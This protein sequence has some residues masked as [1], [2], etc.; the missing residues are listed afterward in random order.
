MDIEAKVKE[1][2]AEQLGVEEEEIKSSSHLVNDL[3]G[4]SLDLVELIMAFEE[5]YGV[6]IS[7]DD[8]DNIKTVGNVLDYIAQHADKADKAKS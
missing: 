8:A 4:D 6:E 7:D 2:L 3:G 1:I 5:E